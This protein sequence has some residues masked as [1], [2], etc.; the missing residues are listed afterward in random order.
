MCFF[1]KKGEI[2]PALAY[3]TFYVCYLASRIIRLIDY[4]EAELIMQIKRSTFIA[5]L[6]LATTPP[7]LLVQATTSNRGKKRMYYTLIH[8]Q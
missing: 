1:D 8:P 3:V 4:L 7:C 6:V 2:T 5:T